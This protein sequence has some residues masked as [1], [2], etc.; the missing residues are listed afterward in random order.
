M[1]TTVVGFLE[2]SNEDM[3]SGRW[4][5]LNLSHF[6][7]IMFNKGEYMRDVYAPKRERTCHHCQQ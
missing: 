6:T 5:N 4:Q 3:V 1:V 2:V 7:N